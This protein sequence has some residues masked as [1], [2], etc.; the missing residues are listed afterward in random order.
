VKPALMIIDLQKEYFT[1]TLKEPMTSAS[2]YIN[3]VA[4]YFRKKKLPIVWVQDIDKDSGVFPNTEG[5]EMIDILTRKSTEISIHKEYGNSFNKTECGAILKKEGVDV[6]IMAGYCAES[7]I[8]ATYRG[9]VDL[10]FMPVLLRHGVVSDDKENLRFIEKICD[11]ISYNM[12]RKM[13]ENM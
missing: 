3:E 7:C 10:D 5:F 11:T 9:A 4:G 1:G 8:L 13:L 12:I 2:E 6:I